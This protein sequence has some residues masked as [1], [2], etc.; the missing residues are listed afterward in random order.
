MGTELPSTVV[1]RC[2]TS[3]GVFTSNLADCE[4]GEVHGTGVAE[5]IIDIAPQAAPYIA[6]VSSGADSVATATWMTEQG[7]TVINRSLSKIWEGPGDST[8][9]FSTSVFGMIDAA[10]SGGALFANSAGNSAKKTWYGSFSNSDGNRFHEFQGLD[11]TNE[12]TVSS[13]QEVVVELR[14]DDS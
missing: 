3:I 10:V 7:V 5:A 8:S 9:P 4:N 11:E 6:T 12:I 13:G 14:W 2:Y 1:A